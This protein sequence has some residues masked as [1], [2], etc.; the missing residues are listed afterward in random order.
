MKASDEKL[1]LRDP[2]DFNTVKLKD[3]IIRKKEIKFDSLCPMHGFYLSC[4][5]L[6]LKA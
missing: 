2:A 1:K 4:T 6:F 3:L 5:N